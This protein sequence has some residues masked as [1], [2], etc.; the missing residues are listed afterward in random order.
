MIIRM[1][2]AEKLILLQRY[3]SLGHLIMVTERLGS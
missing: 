3:L 1:V 2:E